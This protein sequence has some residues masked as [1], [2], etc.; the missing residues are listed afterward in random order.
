MARHSQNAVIPPVTNE[1]TTIALYAWM[2]VRNG[3]S[4]IASNPL[5]GFSVW[6]INVEPAG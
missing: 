4:G 6:P 2:S 1:N 3:K 5:K